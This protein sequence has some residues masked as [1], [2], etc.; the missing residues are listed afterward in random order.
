[1][2]CITLVA[3]AALLVAPVQM[4]PAAAAGTIKM[5]FSAYTDA[6]G[7]ELWRTD[8]TPAGTRMVRDIYGGER[9]S[10]PKAFKQ[11]GRI[12]LFTA[13]TRRH[14]RELWRTDGTREGTRLVKDIMANGGSSMDPTSPL[15]ARLGDYVY[16][17]ASSRHSGV[18]RG[19][20]LWRTDGTAAGTQLVKDILAGTRSSTPGHFIRYRNHLY[21]NATDTDG[22]RDLW[23]T[24]GTR[25]GTRRVK[26]LGPK[27]VL[28][29]EAVYKH[30]LYGRGR[31]AGDGYELWRSDGTGRGTRMFAPIA[32]QAGRNPFSLTVVGDSLYFANLHGVWRTDGTAGGTIVL[33][34]TPTYPTLEQVGRRLMFRSPNTREQQ[35]CDWELW[36]TRGT[37]RT[38]QAVRQVDFCNERFT[39]VATFTAV[40]GVLYF[41]AHVRGGPG[42]ELW[43]SDGTAGG[44]RMVK[45]L[46]PSGSSYPQQVTDVAGDTFL[47]KAHDPS[48]EYSLWELWRSDG[49]EDGTR[50]MRARDGSA[51]R[52]PDHM[53][54]FD[55]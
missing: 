29:P 47:F 35:Y 38:T 2:L 17:S 31:S 41:D 42:V 16:F 19:S 23:R 55:P 15:G 11:L 9:S 53:T 50:R 49:T 3:C 51:V 24:D 37:R 14:G 52:F 8:G 20:E 45:D 10:S 12:M 34:R 32:G 26:D 1:M 39:A 18:T 30:K 21:F 36:K 44:T 7:A 46:A 22:S 33:R 28:W 40:D 5:F 27:G 4:R 25:E 13:Y 54:R 6:D 43:R 48:A